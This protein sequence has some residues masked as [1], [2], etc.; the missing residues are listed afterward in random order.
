MRQTR[1][2]EAFEERQKK[3]EDVLAA[4]NQKALSAPPRN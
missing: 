2:K 1:V 3:Y 4:I